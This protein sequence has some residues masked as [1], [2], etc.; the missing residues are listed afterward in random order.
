MRIQQELDNTKSELEK[1]KTPPPAPRT[2]DGKGYNQEKYFQLLG[3]DARKAQNYGCVGTLIV[4][5]QLT[6]TVPRL[7]LTV[8]QD[9]NGR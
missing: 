6:I 8:R 3:E 5:R 2:D 1:S 4:P 7:Q 9:T